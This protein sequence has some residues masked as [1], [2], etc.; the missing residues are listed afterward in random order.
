MRRTIW[1]KRGLLGAVLGA[2]L[3][4][5]GLT[6]C[7]SGPMEVVSTLPADGG[8]GVPTETV[9]EV[10]FSQPPEDLDGFFTID[11]P[12]EGSF[13]YYGSTA[14][15]CPTMSGDGEFKTETEY[16]VTIA[17]GAKGKDGGTL[18]EPYTFRFTTGA[19]EGLGFEVTTRAETVLTEDYPVI[20]LYTWAKQYKADGLNRTLD[21]E[22]AVYRLNEE[23]Y[24]R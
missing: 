23:D 24:L 2:G 7:F 13:Q 10:T 18:A 17:A 14:V 3:C 6:G 4:L 16:T 8:T 15:F 5:F 11:P 1:Q 21:Y 9:L 12:V 20:D 19:E 22:V